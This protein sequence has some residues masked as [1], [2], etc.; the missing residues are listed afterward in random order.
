MSELVFVFVTPRRWGDAGAWADRR[1]EEKVFADVRVLDADD[2]E[3]W[4]DAT[5][6]V[7]YWISERLGRRPHDAETLEQWW[8]RFQSRTIPALPPALF[9]TGRD[10][11]RDKLLEFLAQPSGGVIAVQADWRD[12]AIAFV[13]SA[14]EAAGKT[15]KHSRV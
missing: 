14:V 13:C 1:R 12:E 11:E 3:G 15:E 10:A 8:D 9:L 6:T 4:L 5:P 7:H 2:L